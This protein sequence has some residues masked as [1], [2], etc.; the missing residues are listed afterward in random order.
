M[1]IAIIAV[2]LPAIQAARQIQCTNNLEQIGLGVHK[3][4]SA[5]DGFPPQ[6]IDRG[7]NTPSARLDEALGAVPAI[8]FLAGPGVAGHAA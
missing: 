8:G 2:I 5:N 1:A 6:S 3:D 7:T 4:E